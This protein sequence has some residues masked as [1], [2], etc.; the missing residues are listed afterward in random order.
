MSKNRYRRLYARRSGSKRMGACSR[1]SAPRAGVRTRSPFS[2]PRP[3]TIFRNRRAAPRRSRTSCPFA[4]AATSLWGTN[5]RSM[6][7]ASWV[8]GLCGLDVSDAFLQS[9]LQRSPCSKEFVTIGLELLYLRQKMCHAVTGLGPRLQRQ[10][11]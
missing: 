4:A 11:R 10:Q 6:N 5:T 8:A 9:I 1:P 2:R 7:G 3:D